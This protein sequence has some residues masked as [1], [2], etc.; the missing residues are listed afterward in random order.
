MKWFGRK[1]KAENNRPAEGPYRFVSSFTEKGRILVELQKCTEH[2]K[3][4]ALGQVRYIKWKTIANVEI[5]GVD[6]VSDTEDIKKIDN[7]LT[8]VKDKVLSGVIKNHK[9]LTPIMEKND[10]NYRIDDQTVEVLKSL[11]V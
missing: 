2:L 10:Q 3:R 9:T 5:S 7:I 8:Q 6:Q 11:E 4:T 1:K